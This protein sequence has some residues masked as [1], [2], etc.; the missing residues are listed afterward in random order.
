MS[1]TDP[2]YRK[3]QGNTSK[4]KK[5]HTSAHVEDPDS[6]GDEPQTQKPSAGYP[7][8]EEAE[9]ALKKGKTT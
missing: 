1:D 4:K 6:S 5:D 8:V 7:T 2:N 3:A 9:K